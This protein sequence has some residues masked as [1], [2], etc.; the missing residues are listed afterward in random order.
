MAAPQVIQH[1]AEM[2]VMPAAKLF[3]IG[4]TARPSMEVAAAAV[5]KAAVT[6]KPAAT[7]AAVP[8]KGQAKMMDFRDVASA[9]A[10]LLQLIQQY[11]VLVQAATA[12]D[13]ALGPEVLAR[14]AV[15]AAWGLEDNKVNLVVVVAVVVAQL[16]E[17]LLILVIRVALHLQQPLTLC[18]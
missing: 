2:A 6:A 11:E 8:A 3:S 7:A 10:A 4:L 18:Q 14:A 9:P 5:F 12:V 16:Q 13:Q 1:V 17:T 15:A